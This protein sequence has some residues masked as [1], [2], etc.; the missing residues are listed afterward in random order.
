MR[1]TKREAERVHGHW[2]AAHPGNIKQWAHV[3]I[4]ELKAFIGLLLLAGVSRS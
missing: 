4:A 1:E 2:N 3:T